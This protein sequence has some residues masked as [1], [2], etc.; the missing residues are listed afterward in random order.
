MHCPFCRNADSRVIDSR[1]ADDGSAIRRRR[2]CTACHRRF[3]TVETSSLSVIKRSGVIEPFSREKVMS[4]VRK[5]CQGRPVSE[6]QIDEILVCR[7]AADPCESLVA[8]ERM[9]GMQASMDRLL[10]ELEVDVL[11]QRVRVSHGQGEFR[12]YGAGEVKPLFPSQPGR[13]PQ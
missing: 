5:A 12:V 4:G 6:D 9:A 11:R 3:T 2:E 13:K 10:S 8:D 7:S 1:T